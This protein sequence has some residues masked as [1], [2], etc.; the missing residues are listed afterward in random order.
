[1]P[2]APCTFKQR[3]LARAIRAIASAGVEGRVE[4]GRDGKIVV[5]VGKKDDLESAQNEHLVKPREIVL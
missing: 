2:R 5:I 3:D 4:I 1:M